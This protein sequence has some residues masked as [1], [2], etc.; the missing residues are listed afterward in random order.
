MERISS[1]KLRT[2][3]ILAIA[4][5]AFYLLYFGLSFIIRSMFSAFFLLIIAPNIA[6]I[7]LLIIYILNCE[8]QHHVNLMPVVYGI[9]LLYC[10][11]R[12]VILI[13]EISF[14]HIF[15][16]FGPLLALLVG[17]MLGMAAAIKGF[18]NKKLVCASAIFMF[19]CSI[20]RIVAA[21]Q[22]LSA[23]NHE[24]L[25]RLLLPS[26][27]DIISFVLFTVSLLILGLNHT[28]K[29]HYTLPTAIS[30]N[31]YASFDTDTSSELRALEA[32]Y[33]SGKISSPEY[34]A[35]RAEIINKL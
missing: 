26:C 22:Q 19:L 25:M 3:L 14:S 4:A 17:G 29:K 8:K 28:H 21:F 20:I 31:S 34:S 5:L 16:D 32:D 6:A 10:V 9:L 27:C 12:I 33:R 30:G 18:S 15:Y 7:T 23:Y 24:L 2:A 1:S 13:A 35:R 11:F